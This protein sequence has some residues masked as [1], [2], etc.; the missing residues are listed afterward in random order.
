MKRTTIASL[1]CLAAA[2]CG[3]NGITGNAA[4]SKKF[5]YG[6]PTAATSTQASALQG[7]LSSMASLQSAPDASSAASFTEF[8]TV[9]DALVGSPAF[10]LAPDGVQVQGRALTTARRAALFSP[11]DYGTSFDN[12][13]CV[14]ATP[15]SVT[16]SGCKVTVTETSGSESVTVIVTTDGSVTLGNAN[17]TLTWDL[18]MVL[19]IAA[20]GASGSGRFHG[21]G[22]ITVQAPT[23]TADGTI[24]GDMTTEVSMSASGGGQSAS[25]RI[26]EALDL[27]VTYRTSPS[28]CVTGGTV[29]AKRVFADWSIPNVSRPADKGA[30]VEWQSC[31]N[32]TIALSTN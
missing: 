13:A 9:T 23:A 27:N 1:L 14:T 5:T 3:G 29:E 21:A 6:P 4:A 11:T 12:P 10:G 2:A 28:S 32:A 7:S 20:T 31:G 22:K 8:S 24:Q 17:Q 18:S 19:T 25:L 16:L 15:T 26:D 30:E